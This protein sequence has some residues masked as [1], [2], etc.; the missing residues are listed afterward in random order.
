MHADLVDQMPTPNI[1]QVRPLL[2]V[3]Q[4]GA[5]PL[6]HRQDHGAITHIE[7]K[8]A[9]NQFAVVVPCKRIVR[10]GSKIGLIKSRHRLLLYF[11][12]PDPSTGHN[13]GHALHQTI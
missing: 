2:I 9:P 3:S 10:I 1:G 4:H 7:P 8:T 13:L 12:R 5:N 11:V 6:R